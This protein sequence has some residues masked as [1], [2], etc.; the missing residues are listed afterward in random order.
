[1]QSEASGLAAASSGKSRAFNANV[2]S[3][4]LK[5]TLGKLNP[6]ALARTPVVL[7][8]AVGAVVVSVITFREVAIGAEHRFLDLQIAIWL[9]LTVLFSCFSEALAERRA[10]AHADAIRKAR[11]EATAKRLVSKRRFEIVPASRLRAGDSVLCET[12][13]LIPADGEI[14][15]GIATVDES[16]ITGESAPVIRESG[17]DR[18]AVSAGTRVLSD[19]LRIRIACSPGESFLDRMTGH[20]QG[21]E[22]KPTPH[23]RSLNTVLTALSALLLVVV[24]VLHVVLSRGA[25]AANLLNPTIDSVVIALIV[26]LVPTTIAGLLSAIAIAGMDRALQHNMLAM[27]GQAI[28]ASGDVNIL[29]LDKTGTITLGDREAVEFIPLGT[30]T[31]LEFAEAAQLASLGDETPEGRSIVARGERPVSGGRRQ[32]AV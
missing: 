27:S 12:G 26:C 11:L 31:E 30:A 10:K 6:V 1:M 19:Q 8:V 22:R 13:D 25:P 29:L 18:S 9:W 4:A 16:A 28:E 5:D 2:W 3:N 20:M 14:V 24:I 15:E 32:A 17:G 21:A 7:G 23:E